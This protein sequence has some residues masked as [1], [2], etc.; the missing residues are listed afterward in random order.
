MLCD[1]K[2]FEM[3]FSVAMPE[4]CMELNLLGKFHKGSSQNITVKFGE[5]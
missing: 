5:N 1:K 2:T 4:F 3:F